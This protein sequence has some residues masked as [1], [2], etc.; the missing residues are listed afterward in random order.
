MPDKIV[1]TNVHATGRHGWRRNLEKYPQPF[2]VSA[3]LVLDLTKA[4]ETDDL[5]DT[6][7]YADVCEEIKTIVSEESF[8][9]IERLA[10]VIALRLLDM[11][12]QHVKVRVA[13]PGVALIHGA[14]IVAIEVERSLT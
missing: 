14:E 10:H 12:G 11:G 6:V 1:V 3:E 13:K 7:D 8:A 4:G 2:N 9:L 5:G